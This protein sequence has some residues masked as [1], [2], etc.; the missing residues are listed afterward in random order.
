MTFRW[1]H[2]WVGW[3][4]VMSSACSSPAGSDSSLHS[5]ADF[6]LN[7][8]IAHKHTYMHTKQRTNIG[9]NFAVVWNRSPIKQEGKKRSW[10]RCKREFVGSFITLPRWFFFIFPANK[11]HSIELYWYKDQWVAVSERNRWRVFSVRERQERNWDSEEKKTESK[12]NENG[13]T[14]KCEEKRDSL[15]QWT[16][17]YQNSSK[18]ADSRFHYI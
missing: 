1:K 18:A 7:H 3:P 17:S 16:C 2:H 11:L 6:H 13:I 8:K 9:L 14:W 4:G 5:T 15:K 12:K 10:E